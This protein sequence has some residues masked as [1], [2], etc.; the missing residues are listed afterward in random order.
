L[1]FGLYREGFLT[2][3]GF[4]PSNRL[5]GQRPADCP[6]KDVGGTGEVA[7]AQTDAVVVVEIELRE[8]AAKGA[9]RR[10]ADR[11]RASPA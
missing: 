8:V 9:S 5:I 6:G 1:P 10:S 2:P 3:C 4:S 7:N 11:R